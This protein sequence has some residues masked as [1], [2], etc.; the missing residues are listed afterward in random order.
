MSDE[1]NARFLQA[2]ARLD[3]ADGAA[4]LTDTR[5]VTYK[6]PSSIDHAG[7]AGATRTPESVDAEDDGAI[8]DQRIWAALGTVIDPEI[9][10]DIVTL[11]LVYG[12]ERIGDSVRVTFTLTTP[13]CPMEAV[14]TSGI[15][16]AL[17]SVPGVEAV[18]PALVW[19]PR[20]HPGMIQEGA[21]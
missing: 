11:G 15:E 5:R 17:L 12:V 13:G 18:I 9:G 2:A 3:A 20:W 10:L 8:Q 6:G 21:W 16:Q 1:R 14:I 19:D 7:I 4:P